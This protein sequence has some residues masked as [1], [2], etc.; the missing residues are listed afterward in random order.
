MDESENEMSAAMSAQFAAQLEKGMHNDGGK[1]ASTKPTIKP[2]LVE[3]SEFFTLPD[4]EKIDFP[5]NTPEELRVR[6]CK[7]LEKKD[8]EIK[9]LN[10][11]VNK[12]GA[13]YNGSLTYQESRN[14]ETERNKAA[15]LVSAITR[16]LT[17]WNLVATQYEPTEGVVRPFDIKITRIPYLVRFKNFIARLIPFEIKLK[18]KT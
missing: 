18:Q 3:D 17:K 2:Q 7:L 10:N 4:D 16:E 6:V 5:Y 1:Q 9:Q 12:L 15:Y 11:E 13:K 14:M 8:N